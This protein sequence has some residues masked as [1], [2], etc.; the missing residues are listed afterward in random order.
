MDLKK[1]IVFLFFGITF[2]YGCGNLPFEPS[3]AIFGE[4]IKIYVSDVCK[5]GT[6]EYVEILSSI[7]NPIYFTGEINFV[8]IDE[9]DYNY[10]S[11][12]FRVI[13]SCNSSI[14]SFDCDLPII[15]F[16]ILSAK[17]TDKIA[18]VEFSFLV[19]GNLVNVENIS[20]YL[21]CSQQKTLKLTKLT[22][23]YLLEFSTTEN[24]C[25]LD[26]F[27][28][29]LNR[30][31]SKI[32]YLEEYDPISYNVYYQD[33][34]EQFSNQ[35][36][37]FEV[38]YEGK[39]V[40]Y[41]NI[42]FYSLNFS[43]YKCSDFICVDIIAPEK[44]SNIFFEI[45][46]KG[47]KKKGYLYL[48]ILKKGYLSFFDLNGNPLN[49]E[50]TINDRKYVINGKGSVLFEEGK[51]NL[52][53]KILNFEINLINCNIFEINN[54]INFYPL[55]LKEKTFSYFF[56]KSLECED[57]FIRFYYN[58]RDFKNEN[59]I[60]VF[61]CKKIDSKNLKCNEWKEIDRNIDRI[62]SFVEFK[63]LSNLFS[64]FEKKDLR[65]QYSI[66]KKSLL[67]NEIF[68]VNGVVI[69]EDGNLIDTDLIVEFIEKYKISTKNGIFEISLKTPNI[70]SQFNLKIY[71]DSVFYNNAEVFERINVFPKIE[72]IVLTKS[73]NESYKSLEILNS[74]QTKLEN[75][76]LECIKCEL[77]KNTIDEIDV[78]EI[79]KLEVKNFTRDSNPTIIK[80]V[81]KT[82]EK[83]FEYEIPVFFESK[84][85]EKVLP[86]SHFVLTFNKLYLIPL[87]IFLIILIFFSTKRKTNKLLFKSLK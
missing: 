82:N 42:T 14:Y 47:F 1:L 49:A 68:N 53:I 44:S 57:S 34:V 85:E 36:I 15:D 61:E 10:L 11:K 87:A 26:I 65:I 28:K 76:L 12:K 5:N 80:I 33:S 81:L 52:T 78:G 21:S 31:F 27:Y 86:T 67:F 79:K 60:G 41:A 39:R 16:K 24:S 32:F 35:T 45:D 69:D 25:S 63:I 83:V 74:G 7:Y 9:N 64:I 8:E 71:T 2:S 13:I 84:K 51:N 18:R 62:N 59:R 19:D 56:Q 70:S 50:I 6:I 17:K 20:I 54:S 75:V 30:T 38:F 58:K 40:D 4:K 37:K 22:N 23:S 66:S 55:D 3:N 73:L 77:E 43:S 72:L 29:N 48:K 46:Y